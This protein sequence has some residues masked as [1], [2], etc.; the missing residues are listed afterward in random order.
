M[1]R[2]FAVPASI[3][4]AVVTTSRGTLID[5]LGLVL[6]LT[7]TMLLVYAVVLVMAWKAYGST[8]GEAGPI[9]AITTGFPNYASAGLPLV[10]ALLGRNTRFP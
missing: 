3:F 5:Q 2:Y 6:V 8:P 7:V 9:Q 4:A 10:A 1:P